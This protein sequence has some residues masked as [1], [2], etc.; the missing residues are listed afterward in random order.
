MNRYRSSAKIVAAESLAIPALIRAAK[1]ACARLVDNGIPML[2]QTVLLRGINDNAATLT[3]LLRTLVE[4]RVKPYYLHHADR[5]RGT[6]HFRTS[7]KTGQALMQQLR[8]RVSGLCRGRTVAPCS[9]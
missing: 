4:N 7:V 5:A 6:G 9:D 2:S 8:G 1:Q 3:E